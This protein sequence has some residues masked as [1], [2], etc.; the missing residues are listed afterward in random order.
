MSV[1]EPRP[2]G[3]P[4][5][6]GGLEIKTT[7]TVDWND[8]IKSD[9]L[10]NLIKNG[11]SFDRSLIDESAIILE[12]ISNRMGLEGEADGGMGNDNAESDEEIETEM[13]PISKD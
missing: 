3:S 11:H 5:V 13:I 8:R 2:V 12:S 10:F 4:L 6:Q 7:M 9:V 1:V